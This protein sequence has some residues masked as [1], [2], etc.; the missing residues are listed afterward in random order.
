M[1]S[2]VL[3]IGVGHRAWL[4]QAEDMARATLNRLECPASPYE[5]TESA[6]GELP[7][8]L[9][10]KEIVPMRSRHGRYLVARP[11]GFR[12]P[13]GGDVSPILASHLGVR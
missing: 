8:H 3:D 12:V 4:F 5:S 9:D 6:N 10:S 13:S 2:H 11:G 1:A 7:N